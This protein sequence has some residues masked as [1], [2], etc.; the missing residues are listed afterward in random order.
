M[1]KRYKQNG[2]GKQIL[3]AKIYTKDEH[4]IDPTLIDRDAIRAIRVLQDNGEEAY[5][6][7]GAVRDL[8]LGNIPKDF[9]ITTSAS[10]RQIHKMFW[11]SRI[12]GKR[13]KLVHLE[14]G[15]KIIECSTFRSGEEAKDGNNNIFGTV[16]QDARRRDFSINA[17]YYDPI[18]E[19]VLDFND[20]MVDFKKK[21]ISSIIDLN[22]SFK[23]DPVRMIRAIKY[24]VTTGFDLQ[25]NVKRAIR[26]DYQGLS[27]CSTSRLTEEV[28]KILAS[29]H[30]YEIFRQ[31]DHY[32]LLAFLLPS[33]SNFFRIGNVSE[34]LKELDSKVTKAKQGK[35]PDVP[36][37][38]M[39]QYMVKDLVIYSDEE[40]TAR[41]RFKE[42][43]RQVKVIISPMTPSNYEVELCCSHLLDAKGYKVPRGCVRTPRTDYRT[44]GRP[45]YGGKGR[46]Q[47]KRSEEK[48]REAMSVPRSRKKKKKKSAP[49]A[50][51][52]PVEQV[53]QSPQQRGPESFALEE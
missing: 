10:P 13:F 28:N 26:R 48:A 11:N 51:A 46:H 4:H 44:K 41:D 21:R 24:G 8:L 19:E 53:K 52:V 20:S 42:T 23:E 40:M 50:A 43:F 9:D 30:S 3:F 32:R 29:G 16:D 36:V 39:I 7:G 14:Y 2:N 15:K 27:T 22:Y 1:L 6:V 17:L 12:I 38:E 34:S 31:L 47:K 49:A 5:L 33:Y 37:C 35:G 45:P 25:W 18:R